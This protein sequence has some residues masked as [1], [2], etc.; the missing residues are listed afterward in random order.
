MNKK[1]KKIIKQL[2]TMICINLSLKMFVFSS[3]IF[4]IYMVSFNPINIVFKLLIIF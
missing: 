3:N 2:I 4:L 1:M